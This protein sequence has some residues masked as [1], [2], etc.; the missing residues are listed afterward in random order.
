MFIEIFFALWLITLTLNI[1]R[2][3]VDLW[4]GDDDE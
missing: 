3:A 1:I 4:F 2:I